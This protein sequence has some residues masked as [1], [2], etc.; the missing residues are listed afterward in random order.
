VPLVCG[1]TCKKSRAAHSVA[2][3]VVRDGIIRFEH[4]PCRTRQWHRQSSHPHQRHSIVGMC[5]RRVGLQS[6]RASRCSTPFHPSDFRVRIAKVV[7]ARA[8]EDRHARPLQ[9]A[10]SLRKPVRIEQS[11]AEAAG[12]VGIIGCSLS[13]S[14]YRAMAASPRPA[15]TSAS[16]FPLRP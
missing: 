14:W 12:R 10:R 15:R 9:T 4:I 1:D 13:A 2:Q 7:C 5:F 16:P 8:S 6:H 11:D 3:A